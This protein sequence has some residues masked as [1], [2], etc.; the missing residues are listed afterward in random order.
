VTR[1]AVLGLL[2]VLVLA[3][4]GCNGI[5]PGRTASGKPATRHLDAPGVTRLDVAYGFGVRVTLGQP[6][7]V[8]VTYDDNLADLLDVGV[9]GATLRLKLK[10]RV[11]VTGGPTLRADVTLR[12]LE[13]V[14]VAG[15]SSVDVAGPVRNSGLRLGLS[16]GSRVA[17]GLE[18]DRADATLSGGSHLQLTGLA[19]TLTVDASGASSLELAQ[20]SLQ[21]LD[22]QLSGASRATVKADRTI[23][24]Q[25]SGASTLT[26]AGAPQF[27]RRDV[28]GAST[29]Q[30]AG[31]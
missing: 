14:Q 19:D 8:T 24:A 5:G 16:G 6:E 7:A 2:A 27:T 4:G 23:S 12:R 1:R 22:V 18:L 13:E 9:D 29:I 10:P 20:L 11:N 25:L 28:S 15:G 17:A 31:G 30:R 3:V 21:H 26:Y